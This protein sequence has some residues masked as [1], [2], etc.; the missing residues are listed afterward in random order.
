MEALP[1]ASYAGRCDERQPN[2]SELRD[3]VARKLSAS[4]NG[5]RQRLRR[6]VADRHAST[7]RARATGHRLGPSRLE[8]MAAQ[9]RSPV[10]KVP[11]DKDGRLDLDKMAQAARWAGLVFFCNPNNPTGTLHSAK[12]VAEFV[13]RIRRESPETAILIDEAYHDY[14]TDPGY[15]TALPLALEHP[16]VFITRTLS[17]AYGMAGLRVGYAVGQARTIEA[18]RWVM[19]FNTNSLAQAAAVASLRTRPTST[20][21]RAQ[22]RCAVR[23]LLQRSR[24]QA[25]GSQANFVFVDIGRPAKEFKEACAKQAVLVGREF[26][27]LEKTWARISLGTLEEMKKATEVFARVLSA[28]TAGAGSRENGAAAKPVGK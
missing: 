6:A 8:T 21:A 20:G 12:A 5:H 2:T 14:V 15:A 18:Q 22:R 25:T 16:G 7:R 11:V 24:L 10:G 27:P 23:R 13:A 28:E 4:E 1:E 26:P 3:T 17:K 19:T 9:V